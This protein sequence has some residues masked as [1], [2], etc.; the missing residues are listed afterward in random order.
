[1]SYTP[2]VVRRDF[3][4]EAAN[5]LKASRWTLFCA[6]LFGKYIP[7]YD[8]QLKEHI[9]LVRWRGVTYMLYAP[10]RTQS[11]GPLG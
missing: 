1:M 6:R 7:A 5:T 11:R 3:F 8:L 4:P 9:S 2:T 10:A